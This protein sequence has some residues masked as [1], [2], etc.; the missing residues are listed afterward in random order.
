MKTALDSLI[1]L[2]NTNDIRV[3]VLPD[4]IDDMQWV[5][6]SIQS[7]SWRILVDDEYNDLNESS[8]LMCVFLVL[9]ELEIYQ[10]A[11]D[12]L[13]WCGQMRAIVFNSDLLVYYK[14]LGKSVV[15]IESFIGHIDSQITDLDY[16]LRTGVIKELIAAG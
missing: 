11:A 4:R 14:Q 9:R 2:K 15:E 13:K 16:Q 3:S 7:T 5:E 12:Y 8:Q 10:E 1:E 6:F